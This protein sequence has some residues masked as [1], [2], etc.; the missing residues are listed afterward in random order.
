MKNDIVN[1]YLIDEM[2][3]QKAVNFKSFL[4][5]KWDLWIGKINKRYIYF[6]LILSFISYDNDNNHLCSK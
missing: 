3:Q 1:T 4:R 6:C 5:E 2:E